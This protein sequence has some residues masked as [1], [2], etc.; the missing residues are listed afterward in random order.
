MPKMSVHLLW[1]TPHLFQMHD[2]K[3]SVRHLDHSDAR[4]VNFRRWSI[5]SDEHLCPKNRP[6]NCHSS[7]LEYYNT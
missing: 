7:C 4:I 2:I 1:M 6:T 5:I 3:F